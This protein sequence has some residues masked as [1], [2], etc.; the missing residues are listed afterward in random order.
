MLF[1]IIPPKLIDKRNE[2]ELVVYLKNGSIL[3][4]K[5]SDQP[6]ALRGPNPF[7]V[8]LD[9]YD[10][11]K[12]EAWGVIEP[13]LRANGGWC[14]F[15]GTPRGKQKLYDLY[16][17]GQEGHHEWK[18]WLLKASTSGIISEDQLAEARRSMTETL[19]SQEFECAFNESAGSVFR[20]VKDIMIAKPQAPSKDHLY[21]MG[22]DL[23]K[24]QDYTVLRVFDRD[25]NNLVYSDR[26][27]TLEWPFQRKRIIATAQAFNNALIVIDANSIGDP[28]ADDLTR[29]GLAVLPFKITHQS[30]KE[31]IEKLSIWIEQRKITLLP[32]EIALLEYENFSY[33]MSSQGK[34]FYGARQGYH[35]DIVIADSLAI[36]QLSQVIIPQF[37]R[38]PTPTAIY[39]AQ[40]K[41][42]Y[43]MEQE[44][45]EQGFMMAD[46]D[47]W[48]EI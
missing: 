32:S 31:L 15:I 14:W 6:D 36:S 20:G 17:R 27:Q 29:A 33:E 12:G 47:E 2:T 48:S 43:E 21:V 39:F 18:S 5:G 19:Y 24:V 16:N 28:T 10:T 34:I 23:A 11:Q 45:K 9:E 1:D 44:E 25:Q 40:Q 30:K 35:D 3:Q 46:I 41:Q 22:V 26:F 8:V 37:Y 42:R 13:I 4:L 7:G 38:E